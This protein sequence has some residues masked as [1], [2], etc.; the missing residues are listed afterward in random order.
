MNISSLL[1]GHFNN[2]INNNNNAQEPFHLHRI[3]NTS[4]LLFKLND[5]V[6][7][8]NL[9]ST[10]EVLEK[11]S[12][13]DLFYRDVHQ[14]N[15]IYTTTSLLASLAIKHN[16]FLLAELC[17]LKPTDYAANLA[18]SILANI[19]RLDWNKGKKD[20]SQ[21]KSTKIELVE[22]SINDTAVTATVTATAAMAV[23]PEPI[24]PPPMLPSSNKQQ[25]DPMA[26]DT[27]LSHNNGNGAGSQPTN[28]QTRRLSR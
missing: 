8:F 15:D 12:P 9:P 5:V 1:L 27:M 16:K 20:I 17:K 28:Q 6:S 3:E 19:P 26:I 13:T 21:Y 10:H 18:D 24:S 14:P 11:V 23:K 22:S 2:N 7:F 4:I 25:S